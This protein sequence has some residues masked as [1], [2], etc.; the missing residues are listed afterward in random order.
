MIFRFSA[1]ALFLLCC[2]CLDGREAIRLNSGFSIEADSH[3]VE[4]SLLIATIGGGTLQLS[5]ADIRDV[6]PLTDSNSAAKSVNV[7]GPRG[8]MTQREIMKAAALAQG[9]PEDFVRSVAIVESGMRQNAIS[10]KGAIGLMQLMP[11]TAAELKV[12]PRLAEANAVGG[13]TY[14]R[15]LLLTYRG[16]S[17]LALAAYNAGPGAVKKFGGVP[18]YRETQSYVLKVLAEYRRQA[19]LSQIGVANRLLSKPNAK[20]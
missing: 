4:G 1:V 15:R 6:V 10:P 5:N 3:T 17:A 16:D 8:A 7:V 12:D 18:P 2:I 11:A 9:L 19:S 20:D 13:A 14:L